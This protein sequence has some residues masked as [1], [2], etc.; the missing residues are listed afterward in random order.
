MNRFL[1]MYFEAGIE[2]AHMS[3]GFKDKDVDMI[4]DTMG[5]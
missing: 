4:E 5:G 1:M 2:R 3:D